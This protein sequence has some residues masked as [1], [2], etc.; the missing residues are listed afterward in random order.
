[1][2]QM[3]TKFS[4]VYAQINVSFIISCIKVFFFLRLIQMH[5]VIKFEYNK[6]VVTEVK[7]L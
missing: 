4:I 6:K 3:S 7:V 5:K 1:M 2:K